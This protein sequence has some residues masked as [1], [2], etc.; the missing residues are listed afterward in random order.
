MKPY[1]LLLL[2]LAGPTLLADPVADLRVALERFKGLETVKGRVDIQSWNKSGEGKKLKERQ[3]SGQVQVED[4][5]QGLRLGWTAQQIQ[6]ARKDALAKAANPEAA[7]PNMESLRALDVADAS[8]MLSYADHL[9]LML[10]GAALLEDRPD[11]YQGKP[12]RLL[13]LKPESRFSAE[14]KEVIKSFEASLRIWVGPDGVPVGLE[15][16]TSFKGSKFL[17]TFKGSHS[18]STALGRSGNRL[19]ALRST[20]ETTGSGMGMSTQGKVVASLTLF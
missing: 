15:E 2:L 5:P 1:A 3:S 10:Q 19:V 7:T 9:G 12:A 17:I 6:A 16:A 14:D 18:E 4:G 8:R 20:K 13:V 11:T